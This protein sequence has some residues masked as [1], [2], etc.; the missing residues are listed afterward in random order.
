MKS[1]L[2]VFILFFGIIPIVAQQ[3]NYQK[4]TSNVKKPKEFYM[5]T[6]SSNIQTTLGL[7]GKGTIQINAVT[8]NKLLCTATDKH[9]KKH[10]IS[11]SYNNLEIQYLVLPE[12]YNNAVSAYVCQFGDKHLITF[13]VPSVSRKKKP[14]YGLAL[15]DE[16]L[17]IIK[18]NTHIYHNGVE[19]L[20]ANSQFAILGNIKKYVVDSTLNIL[21]SDSIGYP[22]IN[23]H[24]L[25]R[26]YYANKKIP[27]NYT[28]WVEGDKLSVFIYDY[29]YQID[30]NTLEIS[31]IVRN[32]PRLTERN[33][34][35]PTQLNILHNEKVW[36]VIENSSSLMHV[37]V[38][39]YNGNRLQDYTYNGM[40]DAIL[41]EDGR[42]YIANVSSDK[43][44]IQLNILNIAGEK[45]TLNFTNLLSDNATFLS[46]LKT[47]DDKLDILIGTAK[48][49]QVI[50][51]DFAN[52][53]YST[54]R[55][56]STNAYVGGECTMLKKE[57]KDGWYFYATTN[58]GKFYYNN[59]ESYNWQNSVFFLSQDYTRLCVWEENYKHLLSPIIYRIVNDISIS[60]FA[61]FSYSKPHYWSEKE[62]PIIYQPSY[63]LIDKEG[64]RQDIVTD[65]NAKYT[66]LFKVSES[67][68]LVLCNYA[69]IFRLG[70]LTIND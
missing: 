18:M 58:M 25:N 66:Q 62:P 30:L 9:F 27:A 15:V 49:A 5:P 54:S 57:G 67:E 37:Q 16:D 13:I 12:P 11:L 14:L 17:N 10:V 22:I 56:F 63:I 32:I 24:I 48:K 40:S 52:Q 60:D 7:T 64:K 31:T 47:S 2:L 19:P 36:T 4:V 51:I 8:N 55:Q 35:N 45:E 70:K 65:E 46:C 21:T 33:T 28:R 53:T 23:A 34:S 68:Y 26:F 6:S 3:L 61:L 29:Y 39:D 41:T 43:R 50:T 1:K 38:Y 59:T 42:L 20:F 69:K 44:T